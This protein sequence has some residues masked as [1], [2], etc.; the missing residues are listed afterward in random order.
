VRVSA[1]VCLCVVRRRVVGGTQGPL[2]GARRRAVRRAL[3]ER[4]MM[5]GDEMEGEDAPP[6]DGVARAACAR[7]DG[8]DAS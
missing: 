2:E 8:A 1:C 4:W 7:G 5:E 6:G 3:A